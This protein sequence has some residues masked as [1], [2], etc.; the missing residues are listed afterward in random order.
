MTAAPPAQHLEEPALKFARTDFVRISAD[1]TIGEA[2]ACVQR[3]GAPGRI[4]YFYVVDADQRLKGVVPTRRLLLSPPGTP[5]ADIMVRDLVTLPAA[6]TLLEACE[7]FIM[8]RLLALPVVDEEQRLLGVI[9]VELYTD[10]MS[11]LARR[12]ESDDVFQLIGVRLAE[13]ERASIPIVFSHRFPWLLCNIAGGLACA[14]LAGLYQGI[15]DKV[16]VLALFIPL[17]LIHI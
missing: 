12:E 16:I 2:L 17:S 11:D 5:I 13:I 9:D 8:H 4:V 15:L 3:S 7:L 1:Q 10:E 6:A 14:V